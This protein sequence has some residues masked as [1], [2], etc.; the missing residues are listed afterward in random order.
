M[1]WRYSLTDPF[2]TQSRLYSAIVL[3]VAG[4]QCPNLVEATAAFS[5]GRRAMNAGRYTSS[6]A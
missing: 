5:P 2:D 6:V 1:R 3:D 4:T